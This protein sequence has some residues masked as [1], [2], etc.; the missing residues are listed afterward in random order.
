MARTD[1]TRPIT[2]DDIEAKLRAA[3][4]PRHSL[5]TIAGNFGMVRRK[6]SEQSAE[7]L[8]QRPA[9]IAPRVRPVS[10]FTQRLMRASLAKP[11]R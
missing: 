6:N 9:R 8:A 2:R 1:T 5:N 10:I 4:A 3:I 7:V 11:V